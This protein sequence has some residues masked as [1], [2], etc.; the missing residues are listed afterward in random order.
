MYKKS[1]KSQLL[2][3]WKKT[4]HY[5]DKLNIYIDINYTM[6]KYFF[7]SSLIVMLSVLTACWNNENTEEEII[8]TDNN[9]TIN[10]DINEEYTAP[11]KKIPN[12]EIFASDINTALQELAAQALYCETGKTI[13]NFAIL[14]SWELENWNQKYYWV[15]ES[16]GYVPIEWGSLQSTCYRIA[17]LAMEFT[18]N[19]EQYKLIDYDY[20]DTSKDEF[21]IEDYKPD[22]DWWAL[23]EKVKAIFSEEA[24]KVW[25]E[26]DYWEHFP[27]YMDPDRKSFE[28]RALEYFGGQT[29]EDDEIGNQEI[30]ER[31]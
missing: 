17:P 12:E 2:I 16:V 10:T 15:A 31:Q 20:V 30:T 14:W 1:I 3:S 24:F 28:D 27:D 29:E 13:T 22:M 21:L 7:L 8:T 9:E 19:N 18:S 6:K 25:Q 23:D 5:Y 26:R 11:A 4:K